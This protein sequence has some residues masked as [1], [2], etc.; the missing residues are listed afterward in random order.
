MTIAIALV[1]TVVTLL[2]LYAKG[3]APPERSRQAHALLAVLAVLTLA[4]QIISEVEKRRRTEE[5]RVALREQLDTTQRD[6]RAA[7]SQLRASRARIEQ[8]QEHVDVTSAT[9]VE[10]VMGALESTGA[11]LN[12]DIDAVF[13]RVEQSVDGHTRTRL[14]ALRRQISTALSAHEVELAK[15][16]GNRVSR[17]RSDVETA[18][19]SV[20]S[21]LSALQA[22]Q[23][24]Q[25]G[26]LTELH[27]MAA[28]Q[29]VLLGQVRDE[30]MRAAQRDAA[31]PPMDDAA[32]R[33]VVDAVVGPRE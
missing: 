10:T 13:I 22:E 25:S 26:D 27:V 4:F 21:R 9:T 30:C 33:A 16:L 32:M 17:V 12:R 23:L 6:L 1:G 5:E 31:V 20:G 15:D 7:L 8:L 14:E 24:R 3:F 19:T 11:A 28:E 29:V 2:S 18:M